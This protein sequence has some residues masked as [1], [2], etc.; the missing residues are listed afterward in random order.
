MFE[1]S[2]DDLET[3]LMKLMKVIDE[4]GSQFLTFENA[5]ISDEEQNNIMDI[6]HNVQQHL[7]KISKFIEETDGWIFKIPEIQQAFDEKNKKFES[8]SE[9]CYDIEMDCESESDDSDENDMND[10]EESGDAELESSENDEMK[11][12]FVFV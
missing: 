10:D 8:K 5:W 2:Q 12:S 1:Y 7:D 6:L 9:E 4:K 11:D 3:N